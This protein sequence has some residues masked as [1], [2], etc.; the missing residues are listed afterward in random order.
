MVDRSPFYALN[1]TRKSIALDLQ[2]ISAPYRTKKG[3]HTPVQSGQSLYWRKG[4]KDE[5]SLTGLAN[6]RKVNFST[7]NR[8]K[9]SYRALSDVELLL[10]T[11]NK[12]MLGR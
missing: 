2:P 8:F 6:V 1:L 11:G 5:Q 12:K 4:F 3:K 7:S 10:T 9:T